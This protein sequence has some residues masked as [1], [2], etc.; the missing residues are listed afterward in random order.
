MSHLANSW[1][2]DGWPEHPDWINAK[3]GHTDWWGYFGRNVFNADQESF[4]VADDNA[5]DEFNGT[6]ILIVLI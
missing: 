3:T 5:D 4:F 1:P 6:F 2:L